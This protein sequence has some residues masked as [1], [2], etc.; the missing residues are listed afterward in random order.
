MWIEEIAS[1]REFFEKSGVPPDPPNPYNTGGVNLDNFGQYEMIQ[2]LIDKVIS[3]I[4]KSLFWEVGEDSLDDHYAF[5]AAYSKDWDKNLALHEDDSEISVNYCL[6]ADKFKG[7]DLK[8]KGVRCQQHAD[9]GHLWD[10]QYRYANVPGRAVI[11]MGRHRHMTENIIS[12]E[13]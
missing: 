8:F 10:E 6:G 7:A 2:A 3:P 1:M 12:G 11:H 9:G 13:R 5:S 4:A